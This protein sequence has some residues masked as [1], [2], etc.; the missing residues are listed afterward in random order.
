MEQS[1]SQHKKNDRLRF[2]AY[3]VYKYENDKDSCRMK[4]RSLKL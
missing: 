4:T 3:A 2:L 1:K